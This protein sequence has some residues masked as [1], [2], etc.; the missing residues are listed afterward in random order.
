[1]YIFVFKMLEE[2]FPSLD[3][4]VWFTSYFQLLKTLHSPSSGKRSQSGWSCSGCGDS[5]FPPH[6]R[7]TGTFARFTSF[8]FRWLFFWW[9]HQW[10]T[11]SN[12]FLTLQWE[13][14]SLRLCGG[15]W[16]RGVLRPRLTGQG[17]GAWA[18]TLQPTPESLSLPPLPTYFEDKFIRPS[19]RNFWASHLQIFSLS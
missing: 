13:R 4:W 18:Y 17:G 16:Q 11:T 9:R 6:P 1:M 8:P 5:T 19:G 15:P 7:P 2:T 14:T 3:F 10:K 12:F